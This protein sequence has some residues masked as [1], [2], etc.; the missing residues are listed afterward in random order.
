MQGEVL[1]IA[2]LPFCGKYSIRLDNG[3]EVE[4]DHADLSP[5]QNPAEPSSWSQPSCPPLRSDNVAQPALS[6]QCKEQQQQDA[7]LEPGLGSEADCNC[8]RQNQQRPGASGSG[9]AFLPAPDVMSDSQHQEHHHNQQQQQQELSQQPQQCSV[10]SG[11]ASVP[12]QSTKPESHT[13]DTA[14]VQQAGDVMPTPPASHTEAEHLQ[15]AR[16]LPLTKRAIAQRR[17]KRLAEL[18]APVSPDRIGTRS[19]KQRTVLSLQPDIVS[20]PHAV[21]AVSAGKPAAA[22]QPSRSPALSPCATP[23]V[24]DADDDSD[25]FVDL[26]GCNISST[27]KGERLDTEMSAVLTAKHIFTEQKPRARQHV[28]RKASRLTSSPVSPLHVSNRSRTSVK[29]PTLSQPSLQPHAA[30]RLKDNVIVLE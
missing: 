14:V 28:T 25:L 13:A 8:S 1:L 30:A 20:R 29:S 2:G 17:A 15:P 7:A 21:P 27:R 24:T 18:L 4:I 11:H 12:T 3:V 6:G 26:S 5:L 22:E 19:V 23:A 10:G 16:E 9:S